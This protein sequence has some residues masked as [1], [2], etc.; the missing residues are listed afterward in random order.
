MHL[1]RTFAEHEFLDLAGGGLGQFAEH[2]EARRLE[3]GQMLAGEGDDVLVRHNRAG[4]QLDESSGRLAPFGVGL[5][6]HGG[7][8]H[9][10]MAVEHILHLD[11]GDVLPAR[12]DDVL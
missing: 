10:G 12:N 5:G 2:D 4:F 3:V 1:S 9:I 7:G 8:G 11:R 6:D